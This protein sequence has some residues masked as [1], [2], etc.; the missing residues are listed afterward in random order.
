VRAKHRSARRLSSPRAELLKKLLVAGIAAAALF[1]ASAPGRAAP[2]VPVFNW[3]GFYVG[4]NVGY[5]RDRDSP[6]DLTS[7]FGAPIP[8]DIHSRGILGG[9]ELG[10]NWRW[11]PNWVVG[12]EGDF[13][14][15]NL[16]GNGSFSFATSPIS[17][18]IGTAQFKTDFFG[19]ARA[20]VGYT[21]NNILFAGNNILFYGTGG[22][23]W[24][25]ET[26]NVSATGA[27]IFG[28]FPIAPSSDRGIA[29]GW[30][31]GGGIEWACTPNWSAKL[32]YLH[33][34]FGSR[35]FNVDP[36]VRPSPFHFSSHLD[37]MRLG[38]NYRFG[39]P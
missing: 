9:V 1:S 16:R 2:P 33:L 13:A 22:F 15:A 26:L 3:S 11:M 35:S 4:G 12:F 18:A 24:A 19:T 37:V 10:Y 8:L 28:P 6:H 17:G 39:N 25:R 34:D 29:N 36:A 21:A 32:E 30:A 14:A 7:F 20:R 23:A 27:S 31:A 5:G 38:L